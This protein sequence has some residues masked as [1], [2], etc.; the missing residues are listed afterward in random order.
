MPTVPSHALSGLTIVTGGSRWKAP[1]SL[2]IA[3]ALCAVLPDADVLALRLTHG[4]MF[5]HRGVS[6]SLA[7]AAVLSTAIV[8]TGA[9]RNVRRWPAWLYLF[10]CTASHGLLDAATDGG[11]GVAFFAPFSQARY[12]WPSRPIAVS[13]IG[14]RA[15]FSGRAS[16]VIASELRWVWLPCVAALA[17]TYAWRRAR[18]VPPPPEAEIVA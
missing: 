5:G 15:F 14:I 13:P 12:F 3:G 1:V 16:A 2:S 11:R 4:S 9:F 17:L 10:A 6:H 7:F 18:D 8:S